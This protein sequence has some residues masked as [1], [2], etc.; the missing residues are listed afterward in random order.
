MSKIASKANRCKLN[1]H[2]QHI[3]ASKKFEHEHSKKILFRT[4]YFWFRIRQRNPARK[5]H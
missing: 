1:I 5:R 3:K 4:L 2:E